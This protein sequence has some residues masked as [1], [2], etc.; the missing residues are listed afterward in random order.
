MD[1]NVIKGQLENKLLLDRHTIIGVD[2]VGRGCIAGPVYA[3]AIILDYDKLNSLDP[4]HKSLIRDSKKL[5]PLQRQRILPVLHEIQRTSSVQ[6]SSVRE[7]ERLG[8]VEAT[9]LAMKRAFEA[10]TIAGDLLLIDGNQKNPLIPLKQQAIIGGDGSCFAIAAASILAKESRDEHMRLMAQEY[11]AYHFQDNVGYGT[12]SH[13]TALA[14]YGITPL[15][16]RN[17]APIS[18]YAPLP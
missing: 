15:H 4:K 13:L 3:A 5:S 17:F 6:F 1:K 2:E 7:I 14:E 10:L 16:R 11:P 9:F 18:Q 12:K 8:I